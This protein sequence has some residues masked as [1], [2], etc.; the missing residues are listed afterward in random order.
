MQSLAIELPK[1]QQPLQIITDVLSAG[2][3]LEAHQQAS[4]VNQVVI[5]RSLHR[6]QAI[7]REPFAAVQRV[8]LL[9]HR[10]YR[11]GWSVG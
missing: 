4:R 9:L 11:L 8:V 2:E 1:P 5:A 3:A 10:R 7:H 6:Q